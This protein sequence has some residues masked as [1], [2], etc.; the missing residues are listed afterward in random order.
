[1]SMTDAEVTAI[2]LTEA[3]LDHLVTHA[4]ARG[5]LAGPGLPPDTSLPTDTGLL[6]FA[7]L[8]TH[9]L[10]WPVDATGGPCRLAD[11][12]RDRLVIGE[13]LN[14]AGPERESILLDGATGEPTTAYLAT[15]TG[16]HPFAPS[17]TT[18]LRFAAVTEE[19]AG[20]RGRFASLAGR[21][22]PGAAGEASRRLLALFEE[23]SDGAVPAYWR[24]AALIRPLSLVAA[25]GASGLALEMPGR[26]LGQEFGHGRV[27]RF[28]EVDFPATLTHQPTRRFLRETG[29]PEETVDTE[30]PLSTL[31]EYYAGEAG[32]LPAH[33]DHLIRLGPLTPDTTLVL[34]GRTGAVLTYA[35][36]ALHPL[37][38]DIST[39]AFTLWLL[40]HERVI[41]AHVSH[42]LTTTAYDQ[43]AATMLATLTVLDPTGVSPAGS[44]HYWTELLREEAGGVR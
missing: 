27:A 21:F 38:T 37:N 39:L 26:L 36:P 7:P 22:G 19:L 13:L 33:A 12:L 31:T 42:E 34:D 5:L 28:E 43:L 30:L 11:E 35:E 40:H 6:T 1:M 20:L 23:G 29:L 24:A 3:E 32:D 25:P 4:P 17:L 18:M 15:P 16:A 2:T 9:G 14:P 10:R 41:D 8:R 44:W